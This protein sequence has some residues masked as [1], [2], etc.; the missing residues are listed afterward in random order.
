MAIGTYPCDVDG[1]TMARKQNKSKH[2]EALIKA[3]REL[4]FALT[5]APEKVPDDW[6]NCHDFAAANQLQP[7]TARRMLNLG[8]A[9]GRFEKAKFRLLDNTG[10]VVYQIHYR[11]K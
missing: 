8:V 7:E 2:N 11:L 3:A 6:F 10:K 5:G 9:A 4:R 1:T